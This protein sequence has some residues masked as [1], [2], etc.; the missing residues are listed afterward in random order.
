MP[1]VSLIDLKQPIKA[2][3]VITWLELSNQ[4][5]WSEWRETPL[6]VFNVFSFFEIGQCSY[7]FL[8]NFQSF[9]A[10]RYIFLEQINEKE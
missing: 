10:S 5:A 2:Q 3:Y 8:L 1:F 4:S 6:E 9:Q 7:L